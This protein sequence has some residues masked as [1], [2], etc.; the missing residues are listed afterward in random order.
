[1]NKVFSLMLI[2][3]VILI[4]C[5][6][7]QPTKSQELTSDQLTQ[8]E[9]ENLLDKIVSSE[10]NETQKGHTIS[11]LNSGESYENAL[12]ELPPKSSKSQSSPDKFNVYEVIERLDRIERN[13]RIITSHLGIKIDDTGRITKLPTA[14]N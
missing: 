5:F 12:K 14:N 13:I 9:F 3:S 7:R 6:T 1:M 8:A 2:I 4:S 10:I 11:K